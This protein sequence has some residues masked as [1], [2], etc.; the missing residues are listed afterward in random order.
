MEEGEPEKNEGAAGKRGKNPS[1]SKMPVEHLAGAVVYAKHDGGT[2]LA[3]VHDIFGHWTIS[4]GK[5]GD[6]SEFAAENIE[7]AAVR[8]IKEEMGLDIV[9]KKKLRLN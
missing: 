7:Q 3:F 1:G 2:Y 4:K 9:I 6:K 8:E 5:M